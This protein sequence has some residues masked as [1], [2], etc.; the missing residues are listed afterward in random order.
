M[1]SKVFSI[2]IHSSPEPQL[3]F[4]YRTVGREDGGTVRHY[5][6]TV[7]R[8]IRLLR[9]MVN[10]SAHTRCY[11]WSQGEIANWTI[12]GIVEQMYAAQAALAAA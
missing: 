1:K 3:A 2:S 9:A 7:P 8:L 6:L 4:F 10:V 12:L 5:R 11:T